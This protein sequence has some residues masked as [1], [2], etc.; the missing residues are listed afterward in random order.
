VDEAQRALALLGLA[1][2]L[3]AALAAGRAPPRLG[4]GALAA[5]MGAMWLL[6]LSAC[7]VGQGFLS[8]AW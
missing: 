5:A 4:G 1:L 2:A 3:A 8:G 7:S 6:L